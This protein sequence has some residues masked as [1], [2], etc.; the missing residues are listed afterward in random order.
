MA[1]MHAQKRKEVLHEPQPRAGILTASVGN[2]DGTESLAL[3]RSA[4]RLEACPALNTPPF[5]EKGSS[6]KC[7]F[8]A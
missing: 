4:G 7:T 5:I 8:P 2:A 6:K 1:P 3:A